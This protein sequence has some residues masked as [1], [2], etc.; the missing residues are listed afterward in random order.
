VRDKLGSVD[1]AVDAKGRIVDNFV[2]L[3]G[4]FLD[5]GQIML[6]ALRFSPEHIV[7]RSE[8]WLHKMSVSIMGLHFLAT[9]S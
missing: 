7:A 3:I 5:K 2:D 8:I 4:P 6:K 1:K 9:L